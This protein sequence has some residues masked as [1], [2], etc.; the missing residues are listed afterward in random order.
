MKYGRPSGGG[1]GGDIIRFLIAGCINTGFT[2]L[3]YQ[4]LLFWLSSRTSY[5]L[6][7]F[8]GLAFIAAVYPSRVFVGGRSSASARLQLVISYC[9]IFAIGLVLMSLMESAAIPGRI[10]IFIT[11]AMTTLINFVAGRFLLRGVKG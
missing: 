5:A 9:A 10:A 2:I 3:I 4:I 1:F 7:W 8:C 6:S 11:V